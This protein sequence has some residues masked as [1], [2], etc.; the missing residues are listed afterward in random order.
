MDSKHPTVI[1][2]RGIPGSGKS[3]LASTLQSAL[4]D[5]RIVM[6]DPDLIDYKSSEYIEHSKALTKKGVDKALH[7]YRLLRTK[8]YDAIA[9]HKIIIWNQP[10]TNSEIFNKMVGRLRTRAAECHTKLNVI[11]VEVELDPDT[12]K[13]RVS[14]RKQAGGHGPS[15]KTLEQRIN[16]YYSFKDGGYDVVSVRGD[17][18]VEDSVM[19]VIRALESSS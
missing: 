7:A 3:Y 5:E 15:E 6:L 9:K 18:K 8:A 19:S 10:F 11:V 1:F 17:G 12:A 13:S 4:G 2:I 14:E 16:N